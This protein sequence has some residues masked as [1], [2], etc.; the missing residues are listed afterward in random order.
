MASDS[1]P[2]LAS[3]LD[4][5]ARRLA[6]I[7]LSDLVFVWPRS[8]LDCE[9]LVAP[10]PIFS[11]DMTNLAH[12]SCYVGGENRAIGNGRVRW[13]FGRKLA[14]GLI[15]WGYKA[16]AGA[17]HADH[18]VSAGHRPDVASAFCLGPSLARA[19]IATLISIKLSWVKLVVPCH[20][21][22]VCCK[23]RKLLDA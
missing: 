18:W 14:C 7:P 13:D 17:P 9:E 20:Q 6:R 22:H 23:P 4:S 11:A 21:C 5:R 10:S 16:H 15:L 19:S 8:A 12:E 1:M 2:S 3:R